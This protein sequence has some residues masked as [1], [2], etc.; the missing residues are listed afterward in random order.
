M[1]D[2]AITLMNDYQRMADFS[3]IEAD[4]LLGRLSVYRP[5]IR[6]ILSE[7]ARLWKKDADEFRRRAE[8]LSEQLSCELVSKER[9]PPGGIIWWMI[10]SHICDETDDDESANS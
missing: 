4:Y 3:Q 5:E 6:G 9:R 8:N 2:F 1:T 10:F 7:E